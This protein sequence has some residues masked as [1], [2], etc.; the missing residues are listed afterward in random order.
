MNPDLVKRFLAKGSDLEILALKYA[1]RWWAR[2]EQLPPPDIIPGTDIAWVLW[3]ILAGRGFG[4]TRTGA[5]FVR[6]QVE[7]GKARSVA[8]VGPTSRDVRKTMV[9]GES[10]ILGV[11]PPDFRPK[12]ESSN[13]RLVWPNGAEAHLYTA[14]EPERLRGP[15][16]DLAWCDEVAAW[17][18]AEAW[19]MLMF[20][21]RLGK[22]P[23]IVATTTPKPTAFIRGLINAPTTFVTRGRTADNKANLAPT[24]LDAVVGKYEGTRLGRQELEAEVLDDVPGALWTGQLL[25]ETRIKLDVNRQFVGVDQTDPRWI[26]KQ[27]PQMQRIVVA[28]D[29]SGTKGEPLSTT[30]DRANDV[31]IVVAGK[32][33]DG[34]AY[35]LDDL[36]CNLPPALWASRAVRAYHMWGADRIVAERN[37][38]GAMVAHTIRSVDRNVPFT[39]VTASRGKAVRAEP[40][41]SLYEQKRAHNVGMLSKLEEQMTQMT[42]QGYVG[43]GSPDRLDAAV[44]AI[45]NL[46]LSGKQIPPAYIGRA[47]FTG[48]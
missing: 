19:D 48:R 17:R 34:H 1:W 31:G 35:V 47:T 43:Q 30:E 14:D 9:E 27:L 28:I 26:L 32:G 12:F 25:D 39:E 22:N 24:F 41:S 40:V 44:W 11:C 18:Y 33:I 45:T 2:K 5:E 7:K 8:L 20:T 38:G 36:T 46:I 21:M 13:L 23:R 37:F 15:E 16:H 6:D 29:P 42:T 10:G 4:K 3:L